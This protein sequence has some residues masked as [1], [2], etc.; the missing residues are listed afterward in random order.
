MSIGDGL[1]GFDIML[2]LRLRQRRLTNH[3]YHHVDTLHMAKVLP[4]ADELRNVTAL[5][6][7]VVSD[8]DCGRA[9]QVPQQA[10]IATALSVT[11][12]PSYQQARDTEERSS[13]LVKVLFDKWLCSKD[14]MKLGLRRAYSKDLNFEGCGAL[15]A[16]LFD[17][18]LL[19]DLSLIHI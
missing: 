8:Q 13:E 14:G 17:P 6:F 1:N 4:D 10:H 9:A 19:Q 12:V 7:R 2:L 3:V 11:V 18:A 16:T 5:H 15:L